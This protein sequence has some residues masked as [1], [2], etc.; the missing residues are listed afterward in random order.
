MAQTGTWVFN[1][2]EESETFETD[3]DVSNTL[4]LF[5]KLVHLLNQQEQE[6]G[7]KGGDFGGKIYQEALFAMCVY[8]DEVFLTIPWIGQEA[9]RNYLLETRYFGTNAGGELFFEHLDKILQE[10]D[11]VFSEVAQVYLIILSL[12]FRG[13]YHGVSDHGAIENYRK[14]IYS[15]VYFAQPNL[16]KK[17]KTLV[18]D[19]YEHTLKKET[20]IE[21]PGLMKWYGLTAGLL[22]LL[23][24]ASHLIWHYISVDLQSIVD[25]IV[26]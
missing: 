26:S 13:K 3:S 25:T 17:N 7:K 23:M 2:N 8:C 24:G 21:I 1:M 11:P 9:W 16:E 18:P 14:E 19:A 12:G 6:A 10:R 20:Q 22:V 5:Q 15:F 4:R